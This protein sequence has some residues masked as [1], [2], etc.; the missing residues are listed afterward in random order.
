VEAFM[1]IK[2]AD[3]NHNF[4]VGRLKHT[5]VFLLTEFFA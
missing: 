1:K 5:S 3:G 4:E 2:V